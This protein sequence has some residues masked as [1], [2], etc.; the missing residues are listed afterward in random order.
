MEVNF[1]DIAARKQ[2][3]EDARIQLKQH[4]V[5]IDE[6]IDD[7]LNYIQIWYLMPEVLTRPII[8]NLWGMTGIGKT[9]LVRRLVKCL[10]FQDRFVEIELSNVDSTSWASSVS[11]I[12][13]DNGIVDSKPAIVLFDEIQRFNT[14]NADGSAIET[15]KFMDFW[16]LLSDGRLSKKS[17]ENIDRYLQDFL[18]QQKDLKRRKDRGDENVDD[19]P[20]LEFYEAQNIK[21][22]LQLEEDV[23]D[24]AG[25]SKEQIIEKLKSAKNKKKIYE[26]IDY[27]QT[28]II[29]SGN[30]DEAFAMA[31]QIAE[32]DVDADIF[33]AFTCKVTM[34][35]IKN[36]LSRKFRPEQVARFGNIHLIYKSLRKQDFEQLI[37]NEVD[38]IIDSSLTRF[39]VDL[40]V[41]DPVLELIYRN[42]VF[43]V[44][45]VRPVFSS[46]VDI[47]ETNVS[48]FLFTA[49]LN[50]QKNISI[51]Y[52]FA[53]LQILS[54]IGDIEEAIPF[55]GRIDKIR[56]S[57][58]QDTIA[59]ISVHEAG[60][61][62]VYI[63]LFGLAPLQ[64]KS[65]LANS[66]AGGFTFPHEIYETR[67]SI[68]N[69]IRVY[70]AGGIA[71]EVVFGKSLASVGRSHDRQQAT[72]LAID[73]IRKYGFDEKFQA[74][75]LLDD[76]YS[77]DKSI[78]DLDVEQMIT[79]LFAETHDILSTHKTLLYSISLK[80]A[81]AGSLEA[82][83]VAA[84]ASEYGIITG[85][86]AEGY[87]Q[88]PG[89]AKILND[90]KST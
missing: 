47:L 9:D 48:K 21:S 34:V 49:L 6:T 16:E 55:I 86:Q 51:D 85:V 5:G 11:R 7:L 90:G 67:E 64:L 12:L 88:I 27:S 78:T 89:Y 57:N 44:Q 4:F 41:E 82:I 24:I 75:Y 33:H 25:T 43:P 8:I 84:I 30:L 79:R 38:R 80:L 58:L 74:N 26:P 40:T 19:N 60:H 70:L 62:V 71:E 29:I 81:A 17:R 35:D 65:K 39:G 54:K 28:L 56:Q 53:K 15:T 20:M 32:S 10:S 61:A 42:G 83:E 69:K 76:G 66:Y 14:L 13:D 22:M 3:L 46:I 23:S 2:T 36:A 73:Y 45:G 18:Y 63:V 87:L 68:I 59:N 50:G 77:M 31:N 52:D 1:L 37:R 72:V